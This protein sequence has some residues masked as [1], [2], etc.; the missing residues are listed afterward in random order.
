M[1]V[2]TN[3]RAHGLSL[4]LC[5][6][7]ASTATGISCNWNFIVCLVVRAQGR[8]VVGQSNEGILRDDNDNNLV[9]ILRIVLRDEEK[10]IGSRL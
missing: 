6:Y 10:F 9:E 7:A 2:H 5:T 1:C 8:N 3:A 4:S